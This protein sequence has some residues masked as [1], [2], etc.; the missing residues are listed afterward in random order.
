[1]VVLLD[2]IFFSGPSKSK[3]IRSSMI[4]DVNSRHHVPYC[5]KEHTYVYKKEFL[6]KRY[7]E[8]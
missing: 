8:T 2:K 4:D 1:M 7:E 6:P 5:S 3:N